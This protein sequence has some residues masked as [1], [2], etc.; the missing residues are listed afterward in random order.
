MNLIM[1]DP[2]GV[3]WDVFQY[4]CQTT[5]NGAKIGLYL[6]CG[7]TTFEIFRDIGEMHRRREGLEPTFPLFHGDCELPKFKNLYT[8]FPNYEFG[9]RVLDMTDTTIKVIA[10]FAA[11]GCLAGACTCCC[12]FFE[13]REDL[14]EMITNKK[15][16]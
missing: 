12:A 5:K 13:E 4:L 16:I 15:M 14:L 2:Q 10:A 6:M 3:T 11:C 8:C 1:N 7:A 9:T